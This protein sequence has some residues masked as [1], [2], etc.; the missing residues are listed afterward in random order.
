MLRKALLVCGIIASLLYLVM[1]QAIRY[2]DYNPVSQI[3]SE[4]SAIGA[5]TRTLWFW[6]AWV[7]TALVMAFGW[8]VWKSAGGNR[9]L[10]VVGSLI[11]AS[12]LLGFVWPFAPMHQREV[13]AA[14]GG[15]LSDTLHIV[16]AFVTVPLFLLT[17]GFGA[18]AF[19]RRFRL[20]SIA[21]LGIA[22]VF[23]V[24]TGLDGPR[25][26]ANL[27][28]PYIGLWE[29][30]NIGVYMIWLVVLAGTL[31]RRR[32]TGTVRAAGATRHRALTGAAT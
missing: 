13:L 20:Y 6:L 24:L 28:T 19:G 26:S 11:L 1:M 17:V 31:L 4:L 30:I 21:T 7:Y 9:P 18:A 32:E 16:L 10:H 12:S 29:R 23:G 3:V 22:L 14:G 25:V 8:G 27:P 15:T 2:D 5:P